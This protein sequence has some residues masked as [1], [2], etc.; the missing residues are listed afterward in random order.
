[1]KP[2]VLVVEDDR[3]SLGYFR[4]V[5]AGLS[6][7][8]HGAMTCAEALA[9]ALAH[10][11]ALWLLDA[12]LPDGDAITLLPRLR[13]HAPGA[14]AIAH[15]ASRDAALHAALRTAGFAD[16]LVK[17]VP[18]GVLRRTVGCHLLTPTVPGAW[19]DAA[20]ATA[21]GGDPACV[22]ELRALYVAELPAM[23]AVVAAGVAEGDA[24]AVRAALHRLAA[25]SALA[26]AREV[27]DAVPGLH[28]APCDPVAL[29]AFQRAVAAITPL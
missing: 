13:A 12:H 16:V 2:R 5:L 23:A 4:E 3:V 21:L 1:M 11:H 14:V 6:V 27:A 15:T 8:V 9:R 24:D 7:E 19:D 28:A 18:P 25:S 29:A 22:R 26:G 17:P 20:A 10:R